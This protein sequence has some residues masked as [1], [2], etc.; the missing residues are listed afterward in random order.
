[1]WS[2]LMNINAMQSTAGSAEQDVA[3]HTAVRRVNPHL[4]ENLEPLAH[5]VRQVLEDLGQV[6]AGFAL[7]Q[8]GGGEKTHIDDRHPLCEVVE[9]VLERQAKV[10]LVERLA[11]LRSDRL[12]HLVGYHLQAGRERVPGLQRAGNQVERLRERFLERHA[13][14]CRACGSTL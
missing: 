4:P 11:E 6:A 8:H 3:S 14:A 13:A 5:D 10:L 7:D 9:R 1:M 2:G 12:L